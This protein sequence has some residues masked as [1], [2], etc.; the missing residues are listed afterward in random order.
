MITPLIRALLFM[1]LNLN[2]LLVDYAFMQHN[3]DNTTTTINNILIL[4]DCCSIIVL[5]MY[6]QITKN[7]IYASFFLH[8]D[9]TAED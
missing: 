2:I 3:I 8:S 1:H 7:I 5:T 9:N 4:I 6:K